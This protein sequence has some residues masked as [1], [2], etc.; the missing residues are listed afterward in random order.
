MHLPVV[1][2]TRY[3]SYD[4]LVAGGG[5]AGIAAA[6]AATREGAYTLLVEKAGAAGR[7]M[8]VDLVA[9]NST[10]NTVYCLACGQAAGTTSAL[11]AHNRVV[12]GAVDVGELCR[13]LPTGGVIV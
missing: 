10:R 13:R 1:D 12:P 8:T 2:E 4:V 5:M 3:R 6:I 7:M 9:H 11:A